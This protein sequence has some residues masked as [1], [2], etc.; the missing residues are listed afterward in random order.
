[1][2]LIVNE[3]VT[4]VVKDCRRGGCC[5]YFRSANEQDRQAHREMRNV[6]SVW[7]RY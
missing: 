2:L 3:P 6:Y 5:I 1:M 4:W 7:N